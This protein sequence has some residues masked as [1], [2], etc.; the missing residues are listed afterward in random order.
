[1]STACAS[2]RLSLAISS[3][4]VLA[5]VPIAAAS[6]DT[7]DRIAVLERTIAELRKSPQAAHAKGAL[8]QSERAIARAKAD[9]KRGDSA[10]SGRAVAI[11]TAAAALG[12]HQIMREQARA[13]LAKRKASYERAQSRLAA[14]RNRAKPREDP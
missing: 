5:S 2:T 13:A 3:V 11:A 6:T 4:C 10:A 8:V 12:H 14:A 7:G 1:M 9:K